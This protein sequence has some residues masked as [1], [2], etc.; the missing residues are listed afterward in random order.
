VKEVADG[1]WRLS[2]FPPPLPV[3]NIYVA[4]DVLFDAGRRWDRGRILK[5]TGDRELSLVA[6][7]HVHPD[8]QG[9]AHAVCEERGLPLA[10]HADDVDAM[11]GRRAVRASDAPIAKLYARLWE[12]PSHK[13]DRPLQDGDVVGDFVVV[14][15]PGHARG[16]VV[17][18]RESDRVAIAGDTVRNMSF[19]TGRPRLDLMPHDLTPDVD[20]AARSVRKLAELRPMVTLPGHGPPIRGHD[21]LARLAERLGA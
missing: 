7:T 3:F 17:F 13:V 15:T 11:E 8:H 2:E 4:G 14:H 5:Q 1:V 10:C 6:L 9:A 18:W 12:G 20:E 16:E 19:A 21:G